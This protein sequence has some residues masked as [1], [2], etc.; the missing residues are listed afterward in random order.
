MKWA[1]FS[2]TDSEG[3]SNNSVP[4]ARHYSLQ[5]KFFQSTFWR[6]F[7]YLKGAGYNF[8]H[9]DWMQ[10]PIINPWKMLSQSSGYKRITK[11]FSTNHNVFFLNQINLIQLTYT[12][13]II[14]KNR[15]EGTLGSKATGEP[16]MLMGCSVAFAIR[17]ALRAGREELGITG[18][19]N[20]PN[21]VNI[22]KTPP[23][24]RQCTI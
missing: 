19:G 17:N 15:N 22:C 14:L 16:A 13:C 9:T 12:N 6:P 7:L 2:P 4:Y 23:K 10:H 18:D 8:D 24:I 5:F 11:F 21:W 1:R 20:I 3:M